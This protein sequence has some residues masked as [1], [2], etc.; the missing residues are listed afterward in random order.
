VKSFVLLR[1]RLYFLSKLLFYIILERVEL[2]ETLPS[3]GSVKSD[4]NELKAKAKPAEAA[5]FLFRAPKG[6]DK[7]WLVSWIPDDAPAKHK[8]LYAATKATLKRALGA[9]SFTD[10]I[11]FT[12][13][14][15]VFDIV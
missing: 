5:Y 1:R 7:W 13:K 15:I 3:L 9:E 12:G 2:I 10:D 11:N 6:V 14:Y 4:F 8:M